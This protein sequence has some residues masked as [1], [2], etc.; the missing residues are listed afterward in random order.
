MKCE[1]PHDKTNRMTCAPSESQINLGIRP[2]WSESPL[3]AWR[4]I[5]PLTTQK[6]HS[7]DSDQTGRMPRLIW[8]YA[9]CTC[10]FVGFVMWRLNYC[11]ASEID[12]PAKHLPTGLSDKLEL[13]LTSGDVFNESVVFKA[14]QNSSIPR[15]ILISLL[16]G[17]STWKYTTCSK[18][19]KNSNTR[20][21][22]V[23][24]LKFEQY[25]ITIK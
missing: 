8:V 18:N 12:H 22:A 9:G 25:H 3:S 23:I 6:E 13:S 24:I 17:G 21:N 20:K 11:M 4:S 19:H 16:L 10:Q 1:P 2:A 7:K 5:G 15:N 14:R